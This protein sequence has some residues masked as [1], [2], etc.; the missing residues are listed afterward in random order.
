MMPGSF[1]EFAAR[2]PV[3]NGER[4]ERHRLSIFSENFSQQLLRAISKFLVCNHATALLMNRVPC[5]ASDDVN[6]CAVT[7]T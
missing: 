3:N 7:S 5:S 2:D 1:S 6:K 4:I